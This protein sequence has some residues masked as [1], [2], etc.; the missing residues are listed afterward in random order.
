M[1]HYTHSPGGVFAVA[2]YF[3]VAPPEGMLHMGIGLV[4]G[5]VGGLL[6]DIDH[7]GSKATKSAGIF[8]TILSKCLNHRGITHVPLFWCL[9]YGLSAYYLPQ[10]YLVTLPLFLGCLSHIFLD[11][12]TPKGVPL[13]APF[14]SKKIHFLSIKTGGKIELL[15]SALLQL[16]SLLLIVYL[17]IQASSL[18]DTL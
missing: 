1:M 2:L 10:W 8:G 11:A 15:C 5:A 16:F 18:L 14:V 17:S 4:A 3:T 12:L 13:L 6:P 9:C 7:S